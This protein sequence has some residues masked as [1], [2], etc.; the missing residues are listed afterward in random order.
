MKQNVEK[1]KQWIIV[2][3]VLK[4][5]MLTVEIFLVTNWYHYIQLMIMDDFSQVINQILEAKVNLYKQGLAVIKHYL[6]EIQI[7]LQMKLSLIFSKVF[8]KML[9]CF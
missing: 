2:M 9:Y 6:M 4:S 8:K 3:F 5:K 7:M 1:N